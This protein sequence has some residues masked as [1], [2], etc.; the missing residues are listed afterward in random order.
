M[1]NC[2]LFHYLNQYLPPGL[3]QW[4]KERLPAGK[5]QCK[6]TTKSILR[7]KAR[8]GKTVNIRISGQHLISANE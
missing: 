4:L 3:Q 1:K 8:D 2:L 6:A 7:S 5:H